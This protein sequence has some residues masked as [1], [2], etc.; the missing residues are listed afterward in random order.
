MNPAEA[1]QTHMDINSK[2]SV[3]IHWGTFQLTS[4]PILEPPQLL[5]EAVLAQGLRLQPEEFIVF[6]HGE[7]KVFS[8][9]SAPECTSDTSS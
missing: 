1:V 5:N 8:I 4:E 9:I 6:A 7:T 3:G 2:Q